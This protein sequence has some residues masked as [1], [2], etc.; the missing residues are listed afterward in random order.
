MT[1]SPAHD[2]L[3]LVRDILA[4]EADLDDGCRRLALHLL[5]L[6]SLRHLDA[7]NIISLHESET[8]TLPRGAARAF[9]APDALA[10]ADRSRLAYFELMRAD[11]LG[12]CRAL[13]PALA[14]LAA[15]EEASL[16]EVYP[17][18]PSR[19]PDGELAVA[20]IWRPVFRRIVQAFV[21]R[22]YALERA[23]LAHVTLDP[24]VPD[25]VRDVIA[26]HGETLIPLPAATWTTSMARWMD[27]HWMVLVDLWT[28]ESGPS[29]LVL[30]ARVMETPD[31]YRYVVDSVHVP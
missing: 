17:I 10:D 18:G 24:D 3:L 31:G 9:W 22:D 28:D 1:R 7:A 23:G 13:E 29:D 8:D 11:L 20:P 2:A 14:A 27:D 15:S 19:D 6:P 5:G 16:P 21:Q 30:H 4:G 12:A 26:D 25:L